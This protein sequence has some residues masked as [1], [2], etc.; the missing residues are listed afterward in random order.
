MLNINPY[1][2]GAGIKPNYLAGRDDLID[3]AKEVLNYFSQGQV[4]QAS[5]FYGLR[6]VGKTVLLNAIEE[7]A[8]E[9]D[10]IYEHIEISENDN[11]KSVIALYL[12]KII[13]QLSVIET[14]KEKFLKTLGILKG[15]SLTVEDIGEFN[16]DVDAIKGKADTGNFQ[17]DLTVLFVEVGSLA[18]KAGKNIAIFID[19]IQYLKPEDFEA[20]I[21]AIHRIN[22]KGYPLV[23]FGAG[24][25]K[26]AK[27]AGDAK[28]YAER[29]F[30]FVEIGTLKESNAKLA[31]TEPA[32]TQ[33]VN[34][35]EDALNEIIKI[36]DGYPYFLQEFGKQVW[37]YRDNNEINKEAVEN[38]LGVFIA[39]LDESFFKVRFDRATG[40]EKKFM[41]AMAD[42]GKG[43]YETVQ[44]AAKLNKEMSQIAIDR[45]NLIHKGFV[46]ST[47][48]GFIDFTVPQF[49]KFLMR[50]RT[51]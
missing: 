29:L 5:I 23:I 13:L 8:E 43:P 7:L 20:L 26:I 31:L 41:F 49:N 37:Y 47:G 50:T 18:K 17:N 4:Q 38:A 12:K 40:N 46:Y 39:K 16:F 27:M 15:F 28:S 3:N 6:G 9:Q 42:L 51:K 33:Y 36:T 48:H 2:P 19:E 11:F 21:A 1:T 14:V 10:Y 44:V 30:D 35:T 22:Q 45:A 34:Y 25:P 32:K 24:L